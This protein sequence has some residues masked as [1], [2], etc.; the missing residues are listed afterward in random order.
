M[1]LNDLT[2]GS[3]YHTTVIRS[4]FNAFIDLRIL[5]KNSC[6][7]FKVVKIHKKIELL[8]NNFGRFD[9]AAAAFIKKSCMLQ[10]VRYGGA[11]P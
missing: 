2:E 7:I 10:F 5:S 11:T 1:L 4:C 9:H 8:T 6:T 3:I